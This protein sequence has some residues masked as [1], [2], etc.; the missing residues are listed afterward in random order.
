M[1]FL[2]QLTRVR[3]QL[4][5]EHTS[6]PSL[7]QPQGSWK[8][9]IDQSTLSSTI[10][11]PNTDVFTMEAPKCNHEKPSSFFNYEISLCENSIQCGDGVTF[12]EFVKYL[13]Y[14]QNTGKDL[15]RHYQPMHQECRICNQQY[16]FIDL[17]ET[18]TGDI[19]GKIAESEQKRSFMVGLFTQVPLQDR[20]R[21]RE[22]Y[23][24]DFELFGYDSMSFDLFP[25]IN[26]RK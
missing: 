22:L 23:L 6:Y 19:S 18:L 14:S 12:L 1:F 5:P 10:P 7:R 11:S 15:N 16:D 8:A 21:L 13:V 9:R 17:L 3:S 25:E 24:A 2:S 20:L 4:M 26:L